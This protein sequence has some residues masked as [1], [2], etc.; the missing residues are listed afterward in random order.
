MDRCSNCDA[1]LREALLV[2]GR[3]GGHLPIRVLIVS[4]GSRGGNFA[5]VEEVVVREREGSQEKV[6]LDATKTKE[7]NV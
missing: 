4:Q 1:D 6:V 2:C 7:K 5:L 3:C